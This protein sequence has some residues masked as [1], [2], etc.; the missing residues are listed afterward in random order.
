M[1]LQQ[2]HKS[3]Q[4]IVINNRNYN[5]KGIIDNMIFVNRAALLLNTADG[6]QTTVSHF[7]FN[8]TIFT[9]QKSHKL[10]CSVQPV[11]ANKLHDQLMYKTGCTEIQIQTHV[12]ID[13]TATFTF[14]HLADA[15][16]QRLTNQNQQKSNDMQVL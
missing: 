3:V 4:I 2:W 11:T 13:A 6:R 8:K 9:T 7:H 15:F 14:S 12:E 10:K 1:Q 5:L 16:I